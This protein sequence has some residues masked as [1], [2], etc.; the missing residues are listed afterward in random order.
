MGLHL[1]LD[2]VYEDN[3][4]KHGLRKMGLLVNEGDK[5]TKE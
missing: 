5:L 2:R 3:K 1:D 4:K